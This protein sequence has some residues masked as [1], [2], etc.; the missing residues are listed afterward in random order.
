MTH[1]VLRVGAQREVYSGSIALYV[2]ANDRDG[3]RAFAKEVT[4]EV[5]PE[6]AMFV[7]PTFRMA[8]NEA[9][10]LMDELWNCGLRPTEGTGSA[11]SLAATQ[12]HLEDMRTLV[13]DKTQP[14]RG[15][16]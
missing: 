11:G 12:K 16:L 6:G 9:Q 7:E 3:R 5:L 1:N 2:F 14:R 15:S 4:L 8:T 13:F 10:M